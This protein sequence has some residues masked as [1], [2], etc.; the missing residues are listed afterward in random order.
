MEKELRTILKTAVIILSAI[1][2]FGWIGSRVETYIGL[3]IGSIVS[4]VNFLLSYRDALTI[5]K[6]GVNS[7]RIKISGYALRYSIILV[8]MI[9]LINFDKGSFFASLAGFFLI[10]VVIYMREIYKFLNN[11]INNNK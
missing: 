7:K 3:I 10:R 2:V 1:V 6:G 4:I 5:V 11:F 8:T 9:I